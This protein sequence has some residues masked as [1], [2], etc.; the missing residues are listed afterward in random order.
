MRS[1]P[2]RF[3]TLVALLLLAYAFLFDN[4]NSWPGASGWAWTRLTEIPRQARVVEIA[5]L[6]ALVV[7]ALSQGIS[8]LTRR[9]LMLIL[10]FFGWTL[11]SYWRDAEVPLLDGIR[12]IY[13][14]VLPVMIFILARE[15]PWPNQTWSRVVTL[16]GGWVVLS[17]V[18]SWGQF[19][20]LRYA[21]GDDITGLNKDAHANGTLLMC[22]AIYALSV[23]LFRKRNAGW[24]AAFG[25]LVTMVLSS[26]LK[27][28][29]IGIGAIALLVWLYLRSTP[30]LRRAWATAV[31]WSIGGVAAVAVLLVAFLQFDE[32]SSARLGELGDK[33][34][35]NPTNFGPIAAHRVAFDRINDELVTLTLGV[36]PF[37]F[38]NPISVG[39]VTGSLSSLASGDVLA[40]EDEKG[41]QA[42]VTL[43][44]SLLAEFGVPAFLI[45][46]GMY[47]SIARAVLRVA[48]GAPPDLRWRAAA[49]SAS[50][51]ILLMV[52]IASLFGSL[53]VISVSWPVFLLCGMV[54][55]ESAHSNEGVA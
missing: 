31:W 37:H 10:L 3:W 46:V 36:G 18:V 20:V 9:L 51:F 41:E 2:Q 55:R 38:A 28:M 43:T 15:L 33:L 8:A 1:S 24:F 27:V 40:I 44:S 23:A 42:R 34:T 26:V 7:A 16:I 39:Q 6:A 50:G 13:M 12:L 47:V 32:I 22:S 5:V 25:L 52:P 35:N 29:F 53:D 11:A 4:A 17:A 54:V 49:V 19:A 30:T 14:W 48:T 45:V 21:V